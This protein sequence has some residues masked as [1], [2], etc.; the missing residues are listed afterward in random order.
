[1]SGGGGRGA[2]FLLLL[3]FTALISER[4]NKPRNPN[5]TPPPPPLLS[6]KQDQTRRVISLPHS[7][8][9]LYIGPTTKAIS[10]SLCKNTPIP[11]TPP[12]CLLVAHILPFHFPIILHL[13]FFCLLS[14][15]F[16]LYYSHILP[17]HGISREGKGGHPS[18]LTLLNVKFFISRTFLVAG[19]LRPC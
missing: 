18:L 1:M 12:I 19:C 7:S 2:G 5:K 8:G 11:F 15:H 10:S 14:P 13:S 17:P 3:L 4:G 6:Y 9:G 16:L